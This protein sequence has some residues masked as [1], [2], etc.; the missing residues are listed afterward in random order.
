MYRKRSNRQLSFED[1]GQ[2]VGMRLDP[3]NRWV[4]RAETIPWEKIEERYAT[5]FPA[6]NGNVAKPVRLV[7]GALIIQE[8]YGW[9][10]E[11]T[12]AMIRENPYM[13][14]F[15]GYRAFDDS[16]P[17]FNPT[18]MVHFR[19]R[20]ATEAMR[21]VAALL[22]GARRRMRTAKAASAR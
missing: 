8:E 3:N 14:Y 22:A 13:Q 10:D 12:V 1:F 19:K 4:L 18:A 11:E 16:V 9:S 15:C 7:A 17:P 20:L 6:R 21:D 5:L 2:P